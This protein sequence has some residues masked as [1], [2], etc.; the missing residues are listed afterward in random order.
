MSAPSPPPSAQRT[1]AAQTHGRI[2]EG[3]SRFDAGSCEALG[4]NSIKCIE[5]H[6]YDRAAPACKV[7]FE[8]YKEC[9]RK[10]NEARRAKP[11]SIFG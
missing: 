3:A 6:G 9:R 8:A 10:E 11:K 2:D 7:H 4:K 1:G 5:D